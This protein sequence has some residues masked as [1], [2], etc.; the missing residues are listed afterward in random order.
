MRA[1]GLVETAEI[2]RFGLLGVVSPQDNG[3]ALSSSFFGPLWLFKYLELLVFSPPLSFVGVG[4][5]FCPTSA[6]V[7]CFAVFIPP[8]HFLS[9]LQPFISIFLSPYI[10]S[11]SPPVSLPLCLF[12]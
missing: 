8:F 4:L 1:V 7:P 3:S 11:A 5:M 9:C 6:P 12:T 10:M 2:V